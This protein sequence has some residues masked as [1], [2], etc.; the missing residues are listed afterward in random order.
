[1]HGWRD[2]VCS[3]LMTVITGVVLVAFSDCPVDNTRGV[4]LVVALA[5]AARSAI[6]LAACHTAPG[7]IHPAAAGLA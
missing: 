1:M 2:L 4:A 5:V 3:S 7:N 6:R